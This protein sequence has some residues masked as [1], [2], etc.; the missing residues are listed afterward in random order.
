MQCCLGEK[1]VIQCCLRLAHGYSRTVE[2]SNYPRGACRPPDRE[3]NIFAPGCWCDSP[4]NISRSRGR[5]SRSNDAYIR[6]LAQRSCT[7]HFARKKH[8]AVQQAAN[9]SNVTPSGLQDLTS[10]NSLCGLR[11]L[12]P[13]RRRL[14]KQVFMHKLMHFLR[15]NSIHYTNHN[16]GTP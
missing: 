14:V 8:L 12:R 5:S 16:T 10:S 13:L 6:L 3:A 15:F 1:F 11:H 4:S 2:G 9:C 7:Q